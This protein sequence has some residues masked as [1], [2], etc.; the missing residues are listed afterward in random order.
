MCG[1]VSVVTGRQRRIH[2]ISF[3]AAFGYAKSRRY[4]SCSSAQR[5]S[6]VESIYRQPAGR[7]FTEKG[8]FM[9]SEAKTVDELPCILTVDDVAGVL[10]IGCNTAYALVRSGRLSSIRVGHQ[11]RITKDALLRYISAQ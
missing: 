1:T 6:A 8:L 3:P 7:C 2:P 10:R 4:G 9:K 11:V 5:W